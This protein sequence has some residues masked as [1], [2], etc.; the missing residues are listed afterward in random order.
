MFSGDPGTRVPG[1]SGSRQLKSRVTGDGGCRR[2]E[3]GGYPLF[4]A[5]IWRVVSL[6][7]MFDSWNPA[8]VEGGNTVD[9]LS[10]A[11]DSSL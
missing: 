4:V 6:V 11:K 5:G 2:P 1:T 7:N 9:G 3:F 10:S 8:T